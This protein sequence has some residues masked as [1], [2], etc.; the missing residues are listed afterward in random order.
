MEHVTTK[1]SRVFYSHTHYK[2]TK[3]T[4]IAR[5]NVVDSFVLCESETSPVNLK[6]SFVLVCMKFNDVESM[7]AS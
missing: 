7:G 2:G 6:S 5:Q 3:T 1:R 4:N